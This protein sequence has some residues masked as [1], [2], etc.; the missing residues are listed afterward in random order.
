[1]LKH[2]TVNEPI[3]MMRTRSI[4]KYR[5]MTAGA[6]MLE[7]SYV[8]FER[9]K[10]EPEESGRWITIDVNSWIDMGSPDTITVTVEP[11]DLLN[12]EES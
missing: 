4:L 8:T 2:V 7:P 6:S 3:R 11:G 9:E 10:D 1:M 12:A 5:D